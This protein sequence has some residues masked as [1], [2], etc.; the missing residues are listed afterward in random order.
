MI[1]APLTAAEL[2]CLR[3]RCTIQVPGHA[4]AA[5][6][7]ELSRIGRWCQEH[8]WHADRYGE[9]E[10]IDF[11]ERKVATMLGKAAAV[12][13]PS[14]TMAQLIALRIWCERAGVRRI[15]IHATSHLELHEEHAYAH[16][17]GLEVTLLGAPERPTEARDLLALLASSV[18][19]RAE[20]PSALL[21]ELPAREIGGRLP[22]WEEIEALSALAHGHGMRLHMDGARLWEA[23]EYFAPK[24][25]AELCAPFD[26]VYVSFY[27]GIGALAGAMLLGPEDFIAEARIWRRRH[28]GTLVQLHPFVVSAAMR[29]DTQL[30]KMPAYRAR[31]LDVA[32]ALSTIDGLVID[33]QPPQVNLF[34]AH[35]AAPPAA[36]TAARDQ[37]ASEDGAWLAQ[38]IGAGKTPGWSSTEIYVGDNLLS[39]DN[40]TVVPLFAK[41][42]GL[43]RWHAREPSLVAHSQ[44]RATT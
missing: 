9:G 4:T 15:A 12:F 8:G 37:I 5:P 42:L 23:R 25:L 20:P 19:T 17:H 24:S 16:L 27:K 44:M 32:A 22:A 21:V 34:H 6:G 14:G 31:A 28:G 30:A 43:A 3:R 39:H 26:S 41:L 2:E 38:R 18:A 33:P 40:S 36:L 35:F 11:F 1:P 10:L 7:S 13:M 29:F